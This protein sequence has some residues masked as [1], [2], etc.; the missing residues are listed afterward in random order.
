MAQ[1]YNNIGNVYFRIGKQDEAI[2]QYSKAINICSKENVE[3]LAIFY[4]N[5]TAAY[6]QLVIKLVILI[7]SVT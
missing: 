6:E 7:I 5:R 3:N 1:K 4:Q 2:A